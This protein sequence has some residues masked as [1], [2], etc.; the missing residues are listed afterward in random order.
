MTNGVFQLL[1]LLFSVIIHEIAHG[2]VALRLGDPT[3]KNLGRLTLNPLKHLDPMGSVLL[4]LLLI[5]LQ[6]P[7]VIGWAKPVPYNPQNLKNPKSGAAQIAL[8]GPASNLFVAVVFGV[9]LR[10]LRSFG[11]GP[12]ADAGLLAVNLSIIVFINVLLAVFNLVPIPP[13]DG[14]GILFGFLP[15]RFFPLQEFLMRNG[16]LILIVFILFGFNLIR[17]LITALYILFAGESLTP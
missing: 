2:V 13:L 6:S 11:G 4:P 17:P 10:L 9:T 14:A 5:I 12:T 16:F 3:A 1:V 15:R 8:A 7:F